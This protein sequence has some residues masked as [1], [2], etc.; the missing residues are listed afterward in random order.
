MAC[1]P[2]S[3]DHRPEALGDL[4]ERL[5]PRDSLEAA[6]TLG[7]DPPQ[8]VQHPV[9]AVGVL[10]VV[11]DLDAQAAGGEG[12]VGIS[13]HLGRPP[14]STVTSMAQVSGQSWGHAPRTIA[15]ILA[16]AHRPSP[17]ELAE[18]VCTALLGATKRGP[19]DAPVEGAAGSAS[20]G[21]RRLDV[22]RGVDPLIKR[23]GP[24]GRPHRG[25]RAP[26][27]RQRKKVERAELR[28]ALI[29]SEYGR[30]YG[31]TGVAVE[32]LGRG[33]D[34]LSARRAHGRRRR[35]ALRASG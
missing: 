17:Q 25:R 16:D 18:S 33:H 3:I 10:R 12:V 6:L 35:S 14:S 24:T 15:N 27:T 1:P 22:P 31:A 34:I 28:R 29:D 23:R 8:R 2:Y 9:G 19:K 30:S 7:P 4:I 11:V 32:A 21:H 26:P 20:I 5:V 13:P